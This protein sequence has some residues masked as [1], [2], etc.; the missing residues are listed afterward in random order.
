LFISHGYE[1]MRLVIILVLAL[2]LEG[3]GH[4]GPLKLPAPPVMTSP[5]PTTSSTMPDAQ[6]SDLPS[7]QQN[8]STK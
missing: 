7:S 5:A 8:P 4:K 2:L 3:C 6:K 1:I